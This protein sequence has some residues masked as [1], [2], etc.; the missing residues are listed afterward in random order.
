MCN[1]SR[2]G[3]WVHGA[4]AKRLEPAHDSRVP[5]SVARRSTFQ[6]LF[7]RQETQS[8]EFRGPIMVPIAG[9]AMRGT[10][11]QLLPDPAIFGRIE[12]VAFGYS[13]SRTVFCLKPVVLLGKLACPST[14]FESIFR[15]QESI[16][17]RLFQAGRLS[18]SPPCLT[19]DTT[20]H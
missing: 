13:K 6:F 8:E 10:R 4:E 11:C 12:P 16:L 5:Y 20:Y 7:W 2:A 19:T 3:T 18:A 1:H 9:R 15:S 17:R 14:S